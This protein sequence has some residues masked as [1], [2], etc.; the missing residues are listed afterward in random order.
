MAAS[1]AA[2]DDCGLAALL[3]GTWSRALAVRDLASGALLRASNSTLRIEAL[4][5]DAAAAPGTA[6]L[7]WHHAPDD[8]A[9][10]AQ[11]WLSMNVH[12]ADYDRQVRVEWSYGDRR[13][14]GWFDEAAQTLT[15]TF[16]LPAH[17]VTYTYRVL[18]P[19][20][21]AVCV[22]DCDARHAPTVQTGLMRRVVGER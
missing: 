6:W 15:M 3:L 10:A 7:Q 2:Q 19:D 4:A 13:Q 8:E 14:E 22:V 18:D 12:E 17:S 20:T 1:A 5:D 11:P 9:A 16:K 21:L